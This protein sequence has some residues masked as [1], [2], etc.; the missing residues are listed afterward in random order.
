MK[1]GFLEEVAPV[2]PYGFRA[3]DPADDKEEILKWS[4]GR[5]SSDI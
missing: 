2:W 5:F 1:G 3:A 4:R